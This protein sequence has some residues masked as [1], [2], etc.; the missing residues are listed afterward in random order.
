MVVGSGVPNT[1]RYLALFEDTGVPSGPPGDRYLVDHGR[2]VRAL[3]ED[4]YQ[5]TQEWAAVRDS[6]FSA[7]FS[8]IVF[9]YALFLRW[10]RNRPNHS[11]ASEVK[12]QK[13]SVEDKKSSG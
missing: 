13:D 12:R 5:Q 4:E 8:G 10:L 7:G 1:M 9:G 2:R 6:G 11:M 3:T